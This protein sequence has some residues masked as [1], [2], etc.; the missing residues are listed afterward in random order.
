MKDNEQIFQFIKPNEND[1]LSDL[2]G[3]DLQDL[4]VLLDDYHLKLRDSLGLD[5][6]V[7]FAAQLN[8][9]PEPVEGPHKYES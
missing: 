9:A 5:K 1:K 7:T 2:N 8:T 6:N 4:L 3:N